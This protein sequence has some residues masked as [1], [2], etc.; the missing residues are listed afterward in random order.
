MGTSS[1]PFREAVKLGDHSSDRNFSGSLPEVYDRYLVPLIFET[2]ARDIGERLASKPLTRVLEVASGTGVV[3]RTLT[4]VLPESV[5]IVA[6]DLNQPMLDR[7]AKVGTKRSVEW[8]Q[9]NAMELPFSDAEFDAVVCGFGAMFFSDK[10]KAFSEMRRV[11]EPGGTLAFTVW[12][13]IEDNE[14]ADTVTAALATM[15]PN[16]PPRFM[17]RIPHGYADTTAIVRDLAQGGFT[18]S[19]QIETIAA[20]SRAS[21]FRDP[22]IAFCKGTP[23]RDEVQA[24]GGTLDAATDVAAQVI[25]R[26]FG[27][28]PVEGKMQ[29]HVVVVER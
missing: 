27:D 15:F 3:T 28:G 2:Y 24:R 17:V 16:D 8:R 11:L 18:A 23:L 21:S 6:T 29:A 19:P 14:F 26:Q 7:A 1:P 25:A 22:A 13:R 9:A 12:D 10:P 20:R 5:S 4:S